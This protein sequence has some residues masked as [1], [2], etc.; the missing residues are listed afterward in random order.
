MLKK[1]IATWDYLS[2]LGTESHSPGISKRIILTNQIGLTLGLIA[3][4]FI[5]PWGFDGN[6]TMVA[7]NLLMALVHF[8]IP[9]SSFLG[10]YNFAR[11]SLIFWLSSFIFVFVGMVGKAGDIHMCFFS[12]AGVSILLFEPKEKTKLVFAVLYPVTL[13]GILVFNNFHVFPNLIGTPPLD[14]S[15]FNYFV[16]FLLVIFSMIYLYRATERTENAYKTLYEEHIRSQNL[17]DEERSKAIYSTKMAALGEMAGGIAHEINSPLNIITLLTEQLKRRMGKG[18][19]SETEFQEAI[20][21]IN[22]TAH[23]IGVIITALRSFSRS[24]E[25]LPLKNVNVRSLLEET[26]ILCHE[27]F[28]NRGI[29]LTVSYLKE[30]SLLVR[31]RPVEISQV[32]LNVLNNACDA[33]TQVEQPLIEIEVDAIG[34]MLQIRIDDNGPGIREDLRQKIFDPFFTTKEVGKG[35]GLGLS[36]SKGIMEANVGRLFLDSD[37]PKTRFILELK[38]A[39]TGSELRSEKV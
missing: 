25:G 34:E 8:L 7:L 32:L 5:F 20:E 33:L 39:R 9:Y 37:S 13:F 15:S 12:M 21:K 17:L 10:F 14:I 11:F 28:R 24:T 35:T 23:R 2:H 31:C 26:L 3:F 22:S 6:L 4:G 30:T 1:V 36:I 18:N 19:V 27:R 38:A 29:Q 16:N